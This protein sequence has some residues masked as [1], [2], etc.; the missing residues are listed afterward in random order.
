MQVMPLDDL[1]GFR[2]RLLVTPAEGRV[3]SELACDPID[4]KRRAEP[5][6]NGTTVLSFSV[7]EGRSWNLLS[8]PAEIG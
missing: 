1:P 6:R 7:V 8:W 4:G 5:C 3:V 2:R